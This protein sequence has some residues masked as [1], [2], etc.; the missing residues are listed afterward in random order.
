MLLQTNSEFDRAK[1]VMDRGYGRLSLKRGPGALA[2]PSS[3]VA[4]KF[5]E[6]GRDA[7]QRVARLGF[8]DHARRFEPPSGDGKR[9]AVQG[10]LRLTG[11]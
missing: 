6:Q 8:V 1:A 3:P 5:V 9:V 7:P 4:R 2:I 11:A 10:D